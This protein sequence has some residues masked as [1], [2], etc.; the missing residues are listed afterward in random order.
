M[1]ALSK[2]YKDEI[3]ILCGI[4]IGTYPHLYDLHTASAKAE[5]KDY[6]YCLIEHIAEDKSVVG[7]NLFE[8]CR[9]L[10][11]FIL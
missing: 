7:K 3:R 11:I 1:R 9:D 6:D 8:F 4:E 5:I 10:P 2:K